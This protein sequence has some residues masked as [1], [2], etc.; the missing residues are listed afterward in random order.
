MITK[1]LKSLVESIKR[2][3]DTEAIGIIGGDKIIWEV[4][5]LGIW[6]KRTER[7]W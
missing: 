2:R 3:M 1:Q 5:Y 7:M 6:R 4:G